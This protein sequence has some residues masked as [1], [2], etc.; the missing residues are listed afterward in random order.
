MNNLNIIF[1]DIINTSLN[2]LLESPF[3]SDSDISF[4]NKF[5]V[6]GVKKEKACSLILKNKYVGE[7]RIDENGKP[8]SDHFYFNISHSDGA[9]VFIKDDYP[10]GIDIEKIRPVEDGLIDFI[11][12]REERDYIKTPSNF[13]EI[14]TNKESLSKAIGTGIKE[15]IK[16]IPGLPINGKKE[17]KGKTFQSKTIKYKEFIVSVNREKDEQFEINIKEEQ[18]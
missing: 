3:L 10:I 2:Y 5:K 1:I 13:F 6:E 12:F 17:Y 15:V 8:V 18:L 11:S 16:E 4:L 9:V 14:W 7:Y